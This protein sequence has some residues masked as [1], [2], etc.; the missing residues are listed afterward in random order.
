LRLAFYPY[1]STSIDFYSDDNKP[2]YSLNGG[3]DMKLGITKS[4]TLDL[5]LVPDFSHVQSDEEELNLSPF[6]TYYSENRPFFTEGVELF[7]KVGLFYSRRIGKIPAKY[8]EIRAL[9]DSGYIIID[10]PRYSKLINAIKL[11]GRDDKNLAIGIFNATTANTWAE[12]KDSLGNIKKILTEPW[13]NYNMI[14]LDKL[15]KECS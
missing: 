14:V 1:V 7:E 12:V 15:V 2:T 5:T 10:N 4:H 9:Q 8:Y 3:L 13:A 6:E 11:S